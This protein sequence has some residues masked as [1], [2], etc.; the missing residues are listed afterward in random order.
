MN[1][2]EKLEIG[3]ID[4]ER[5]KGLIFDVDG[6][7]SDTDDQMIDSMKRFLQP[8]SFLF[9]N[10]DPHQFARWFVTAIETPANFIYG[11][12][13]RLSVDGALIRLHQK[14]TQKQK[15]KHASHEQ[16]LI[17]PGV[18]SMLETLSNKFPMAIVS[19]RDGLTTHQFLEYF[20]LLPYFKVVVTSQT[21]QRTKPSPE[22]IL[23]AAEQL[24]LDVRACLM[25]GDTIV[26]VRAGRSAGAQTV[27][28]LCGFGTQGELKRAGADLILSNTPDLVHN[29][30]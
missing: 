25:I 16:F 20:D 21:C 28:V 15:A 26:D 9:K 22:P 23:Y 11:L 27:G 3:A 14:L 6:T 1:K 24:G 8:A 2:N 5:V 7:L 30:D 10:K 13:D 4:Q 18:V 17:I 12:A 29:F 19:S